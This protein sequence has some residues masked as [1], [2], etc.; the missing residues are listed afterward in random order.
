MKNKNKLL[1]SVNTRL[2]KNN[3]LPHI[4]SSLA[5][6]IFYLISNYEDVDDELIK[7]KFLD[8]VTRNN[9]ENLLDIQIEYAVQ[10]MDHNSKLEYEEVH[11]VFSLVDEIFALKKLGLKTDFLCHIYEQKLK[12][13]LQKEFTRA[14]MVVEDRWEDW[15]KDW[16]WYRI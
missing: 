14:K 6:D 4:V 11:K 7:N 16:W 3:C 2:K 13:F 8:Y 9:Q 5:Y 1:H 15:K 10:L 12:I